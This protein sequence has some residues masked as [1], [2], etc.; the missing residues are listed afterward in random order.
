MLEEDGSGCAKVSLDGCAMPALY[1]W[2]THGG[3]LHLAPR[4]WCPEAVREGKLIG[5]DPPVNKLRII[6]PAP[7]E[8]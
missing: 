6:E 2:W 5:N 1:V 4:Y 8:L 3:D 7:G